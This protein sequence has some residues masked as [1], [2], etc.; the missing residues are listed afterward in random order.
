MLNLPVDM[1]PTSNSLITWPREIVRSDIPFIVRRSRP[2][3]RTYR[4]TALRL[5]VE[6]MD[7]SSN[8]LKL[9]ISEAPGGIFKLWD[10]N[11]NSSG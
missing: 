9:T 7:V 5:V 6:A 8:P 10:S 2:N 11:A 3:H 1:N 4:S